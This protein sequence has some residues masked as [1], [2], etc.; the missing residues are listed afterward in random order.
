[1]LPQF[2]YYLKYSY[3]VSLLSR[4]LVLLYGEVEKLF[5]RAFLYSRA[6]FLP[7]LVY[8]LAHLVSRGRNSGYSIL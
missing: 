3:G 7:R 4:L 6:L 5:F 2:L 1:M 8:Q